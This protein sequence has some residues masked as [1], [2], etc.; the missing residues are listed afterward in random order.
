MENEPAEKKKPYEELFNNN[1]TVMLL[2]DPETAEIVNANPAACS[3]YGYSREQLKR[4]KI[5]D[6]NTLSEREVFEEM[7]RA[8]IENRQYLSLPA[9]AR[10]RPGTRR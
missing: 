10:R 9:P 7:E 1:H 4:K 8:R 2:I 3:F 6:I 5:T